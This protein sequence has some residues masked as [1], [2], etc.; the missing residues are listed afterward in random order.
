MAVP[1]AIDERVVHLSEYHPRFRSF[2]VMRIENGDIR[3]QAI[4]QAKRVNLAIR[5]ICACTAAGQQQ[6]SRDNRRTTP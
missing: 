2:R 4:T 5:F 6:E 3:N 1:A